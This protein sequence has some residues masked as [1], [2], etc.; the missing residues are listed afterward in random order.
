[1][2]DYESLW[3][4]EQNVQKNRPKLNITAGLFLLTAD[5]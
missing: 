1:M 5:N 3:Q 4:S 2:N